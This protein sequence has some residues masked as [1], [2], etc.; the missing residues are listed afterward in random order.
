MVLCLL[1]RLLPFADNVEEIA[2]ADNKA[3]IQPGARFVTESLSKLRTNM[4][5]TMIF[6]E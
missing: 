4:V 6:T 5:L 3:I 2:K 1:R